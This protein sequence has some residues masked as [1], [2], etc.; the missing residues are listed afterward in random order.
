GR[1]V[2][3]TLAAVLTKEPESHRIPVPM[4]RLVSRCLEKNVKRRLQAIGEARILLEDSGTSQEESAPRPRRP[5]A[6]IGVSAI[7]LLALM[8]V[9][10]IHFRKALTPQERSVRFQVPLPEKSTGAT[11]QLSPDGH[12]LAIA[13]T[14]GGSS[15]LWVRPLDSLEVRALPGTEDAGFPFWSPD[16]AFIGFF[17][18]RKLKRIALAGGSP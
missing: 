4:R 8:A 9:S 17:A 7:L 12:Y 18:Q 6:W 10:F 1:T 16:G 11:F 15:R 13:A 14:G 2:S 3:D 5:L